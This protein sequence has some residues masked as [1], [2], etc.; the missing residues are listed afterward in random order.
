MGVRLRL[1]VLVVRVRHCV[2]VQADA[3]SFLGDRDVR[4]VKTSG[5]AMLGRSQ[6]GRG[7]MGAAGVVGIEWKSSRICPEWSPD[8][9]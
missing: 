1:V 7:R 2:E 5:P 4:R 8:G 9:F 6:R 3:G